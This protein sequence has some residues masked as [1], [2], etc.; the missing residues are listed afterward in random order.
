[1][2]N[3]V[4]IIGGFIKLLGASD[5]TKIG[6][7]LDALKVIWQ[8]SSGNEVGTIT[9]PVHVTPIPGSSKTSKSQY[10][11]AL[12]VPSG[13]TTTILTYTVPLAKTAILERVSVTGEN[14]AYYRVLKNA[15]V[16]DAKHTNFGTNLNEQFEYV[17]SANSGLLLNTG[18]VI[19]VTVLHQRSSLANF[20]ARLQV[21]EY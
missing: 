5:N 12:S 10:N 9:N 15:V 7:V 6:N 2:F 17:S 11:E 18:D 20:S 19:T 3:L 21:T 14:I 16:M 13:V 8:D 1:M 4:R